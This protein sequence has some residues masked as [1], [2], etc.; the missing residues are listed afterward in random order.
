MRWWVVVVVV[1]VVAVVAVVVVVMAA[2][3][4]ASMATGTGPWSKGSQGVWMASRVG[5]MRSKGGEGCE[6]PSRQA[7]T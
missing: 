5:R 4:S 1:A 7:G 6:R 2:V 3:G